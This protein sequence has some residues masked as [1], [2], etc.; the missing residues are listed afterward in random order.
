M[1]SK[2]QKIENGN[3]N[4]QAQGNVN[5]NFFRDYKPNAIRFY[6]NDICEVLKKFEEHADDIDEY[7]GDASLSELELI[8]KP[9]KNIL[10]NLSE[11]YFTI[12]CDEYLTYFRK[13]DQFLKAPQNKEYMKLYRKTATQLN[14][15]ISVLRKRYEYFEEVLHEIL[16]SIISN[17]KSK[18]V[19]NI[20]VFIIFINYMYWNCDIGKRK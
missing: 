19:E 9:E 1:L 2:G 6:E 16:N 4:I 13:I 17:E 7:E 10:N 3:G 14:F 12:I 5:V 20:D 8:E 15:R 11:D 18:V